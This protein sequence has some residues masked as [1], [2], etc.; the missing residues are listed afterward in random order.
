MARASSCPLLA[1]G[2]GETGF[3]PCPHP[4]GGRRRA[5]PARR[6][7]GKPGFSTPPP[8]EGFGGRSPRAGAWGNR[9]SPHL[10]RGRVSEGAA[11]AQGHGETGFPQ[12]RTRWA[13]LGGR[14]PPGNNR[15][16]IPLVCGAAA[17]TA[18]QESY[19]SN[20]QR[21]CTG[22]HDPRAPEAYRR[23]QASASSRVV[24]SPSR[25]AARSAS[26]V[27]PRRGPGAMPRRRR[28][29]PLSGARMVRSSRR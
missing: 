6:G 11:R 17:W 18:V 23:T 24:T 12:T 25:A 29:L 10:P 4:V 22:P 19:R 3:P 21:S 8:R 20:A 27:R 1:Q 9:V 16:F 5:Q 14:S 7:M 26:S 2:H 13:G 28:S 15:M